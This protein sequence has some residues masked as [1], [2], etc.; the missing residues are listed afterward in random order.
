MRQGWDCCWIKIL[1]VVW[2]NWN[3]NAAY[4]RKNGYHY[5]ITFAKGIAIT[6]TENKLTKFVHSVTAHNYHADIFNSYLF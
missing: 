6:A 3:T 2:I 5:K 1:T 4:K